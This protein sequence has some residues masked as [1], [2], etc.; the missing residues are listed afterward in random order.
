MYITKNDL[1]AIYILP[2]GSSKGRL[3][4]NYKYTLLAETRNIGVR[5]LQIDGAKKATK[6][7]KPYIYYNHQSGGEGL[8]QDVSNKLSAAGIEH[9]TFLDKSRDSVPVYT[10]GEFG[11]VVSL[12]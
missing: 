1:K 6:S 12:N 7:D 9:W 11:S 8:T 5:F 4:I 10:L 2:L 3:H